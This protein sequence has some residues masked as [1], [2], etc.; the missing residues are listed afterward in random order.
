[1]IETETTWEDSGYDCDH[2]GGEIL[3]RTDYET[4]QLPRSVYQ[5]K[6][7]GCQWSLDGDTVRVG[8]GEQCRAAQ[9]EKQ[10][11]IP[12]PPQLSRRT[13]VILGILLL[14]VTLRFGGFTLLRLLLPL[15]VA[16]LII[17]SVVRFGR[18]QQWW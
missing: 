12:V 16:A 7:C 4:G 2:C 14:I 18:E 3:K 11:E 9:R 17:F 6:R 10:P 8:S 5:C 13:I 15:A 1:M